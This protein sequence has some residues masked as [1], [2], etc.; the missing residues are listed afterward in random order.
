MYLTAW[1][2][3]FHSR[4]KQSSQSIFLKHWIVCKK[5]LEKVDP[6]NEVEDRNTEKF[7]DLTA[8][9]LFILFNTVISPLKSL[10]KAESELFTS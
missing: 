8:F 3:D 2:H 4:L 5:L 9:F 6:R 10:N 1:G 7:N